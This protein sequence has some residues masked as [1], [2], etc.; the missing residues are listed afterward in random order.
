[1]VFSEGEKSGGLEI[2]V[3]SQK[4]PNLGEEDEE[5]LAAGGCYLDTG[6][7]DEEETQQHGEA[8]NPVASVCPRW[9][10]PRL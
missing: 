6:E 5:H 1:V 7:D 10:C 9:R 2:A 3:C 8:A 4:L